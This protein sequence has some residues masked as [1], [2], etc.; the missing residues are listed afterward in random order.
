VI[1][2][3]SENHGLDSSFRKLKKKRAEWLSP[4]RSEAV[5]IGVS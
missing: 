2:P 1:D 3:A 4:A 5:F